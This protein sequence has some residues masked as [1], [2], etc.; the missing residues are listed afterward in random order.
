MTREQFLFSLGLF[1][2]ASPLAGSLL[3]ACSAPSSSREPLFKSG[4]DGVTF[5]SMGSKLIGGFYKA[6]G[7]T[8]RPTAI[9]LHGLPGI[10]KHL[11]IAYRLRDMGWNCLYFHFRGSWGSG[12]NYSLLGLHQDTHAAVEWVKQQSCVDK[13]KI[14]LIGASTGSHPAFVCGADNLGVRAIVGIS[15]VVKPGAF[16]FSD[17]MAESFSNMLTETTAKELVAEWNKLIDLKDAISRF[18]PR[19]ACMIAAGKDDIFPFEQYADVAAEFDSID[20]ITKAGADHGF[21]DCRPWLVDTVTKW[22]TQAVD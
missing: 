3:S 9:T 7:Q 10:E 6:S 2:G 15:P 20:W 17:D 8:S 5:T 4:L 18:V 13:N 14:V 21:S 1:A 12:G 19:R 16:S 22:L 11:D